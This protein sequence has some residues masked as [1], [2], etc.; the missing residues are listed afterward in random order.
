MFRAKTHDAYTI[1]ILIELLHNN[2]KTG[3]FELTRDSIRLCM[4]D[5]NCRTLIHARL[6][7]SDFHQFHLLQPMN[8]GLNI[9]HFHKMLKGVKKKD[10]LVMFVAN[11]RPNELGLQII[12]KDHQRLT[13]SYIRIQSIQNLEILLPEP[14][15]Q[16]VLVSSAEFSKMCKDM[17][18]ISNTISVF[19][20]DSNVKFVCHLGSVYSREIILGET[21]QWTKTEY[22]YQDDFDADQLL[23]IMKMSGFA[24]N[25]SIHCQP[26]MP[27]MIQSKVGTLGEIAIYIKS[28]RQ[29]EEE[30]ILHSEVG[31]TVSPSSTTAA[32][33]LMV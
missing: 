12:P 3:C 23:R 21:D 8:M 20:N 10:A 18:T 13:I 19:V 31:E 16:S 1:K 2:I 33:K 5:S 24:P 9:N 11:D 27:M 6:R 14:Y 29:I 30:E 7:A 26:A 4:T 22:P 25:L 28:K 17:F 15:Y 32:G